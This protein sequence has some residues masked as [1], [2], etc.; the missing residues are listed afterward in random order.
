MYSAFAVNYRCHVTGIRR[1]QCILLK[2]ALIFG[3]EVFGGVEF[4]GNKYILDAVNSHFIPFS[5][6]SSVM[7]QKVMIIELF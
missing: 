4:K 6:Y 5:V 7:S 2:T 1:L 3:V